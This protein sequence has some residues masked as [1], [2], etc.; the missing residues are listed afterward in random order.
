MGMPVEL[1]VSCLMTHEVASTGAT[2]ILT[3]QGLDGISLGKPVHPDVRMV[4][5]AEQTIRDALRKLPNSWLV[6]VD[7]THVK[8]QPVIIA[9][10]LTHRQTL[11][12]EVKALEELI[13]T[14]LGEPKVMLVVRSQIPNDVTSRGRILLGNLTFNPQNDEEG[15]MVRLVNE[16]VGKLGKLFVSNM[17]G[18]W[19]KDHWELYAEIQGERVITE[20]EVS[21][22]EKQVSAE[23]KK[24][25]KL[26]AWSRAELVVTDLQSYATGAFL[27]SQRGKSVFLMDEKT[28]EQRMKELVKPE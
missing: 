11:P 6:D 21:R 2:D 20:S 3:E 24:N 17:D 18:V 10:L 23:I 19:H 28:L 8:K 16:S 27:E 25:V 9:T 26:R 14:R 7:L 15:K 5:I 13:N 22:I 1:T 4:R 12:S